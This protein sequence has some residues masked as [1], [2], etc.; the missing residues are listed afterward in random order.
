MRVQFV[1]AVTLG[2]TLILV[3]RGLKSKID[4]PHK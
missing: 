3:L 2:F 1:V 4:E